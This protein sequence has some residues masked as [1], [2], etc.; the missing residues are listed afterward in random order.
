MYIQGE[1]ETQ[2]K[3]ITR[4]QGRQG[5]C[6]CWPSSSE[7]IWLH[8]C[9]L[10]VS[11]SP[12]FPPLAPYGTLAGL[13]RNRPSNPSPIHPYGILTKT[14]ICLGPWVAPSLN[15]LSCTSMPDSLF[16]M[17]QEH[18]GRCWKNKDSFTSCQCNP[19]GAALYL[20]I[21]LTPVSISCMRS[22]RRGHTEGQA[23]HLS[24]Q[25]Q[26]TLAGDT[27]QSELIIEMHCVEKQGKSSRALWKSWH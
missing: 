21:C 8:S 19:A 25:T 4:T 6:L 18:L 24:E 22:K 16:F 10:P 20:S 15:C 2:S 17:V 11:M 1:R 9:A 12:V 13:G 3:D 5:L 27:F 14:D 26:D 23:R 7:A